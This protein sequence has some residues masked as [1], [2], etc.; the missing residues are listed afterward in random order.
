MKLTTCLPFASSVPAALCLTM[1]LMLT[2]IGPH[3]LAAPAQTSRTSIQVLK[4]SGPHEIS[5]APHN[6]ISFHFHVSGLTYGPNYGP[7][8]GNK[9]GQGHIEM[10][11]D[12]LPR[13]AYD[14]VDLVNLFN[15]GIRSLDSVSIGVDDAYIKILK[16][17]HTLLI[18]LARNDDV[19]YKVKPVRFPLLIK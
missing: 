7:K 2:S 14:R 4:T 15:D 9:P 10:Y 13:D 16:G 3:T 8:S 17:H 11:I 5:E 1:G 6:N 12:R 19:L 18:V